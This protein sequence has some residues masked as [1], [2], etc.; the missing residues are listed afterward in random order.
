MTMFGF[1][2]REKR[3]TA[4]AKEK[5]DPCGM[6]TRKATATATAT[7]GVLPHS[8]SLRVRWDEEGVPSWY[9]L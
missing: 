1:G 7:A 4:D 2:T 5:A 9:V 6:T 3:A 8:T